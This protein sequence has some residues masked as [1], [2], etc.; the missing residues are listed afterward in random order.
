MNFTN[1][2]MLSGVIWVLSMFVVFWALFSTPIYI[3][4]AFRYFRRSYKFTL[5][6]KSNW[7]RFELTAPAFFVFFSGIGSALTL[8]ALLTGAPSLLSAL[9]GGLA[10]IALISLIVGACFGGSMHVLLTAWG[11]AYVDAFLDKNR[12]DKNELMLKYLAR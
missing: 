12:I 6:P 11:R 8:V 1:L 10:S 5:P 2:L 4:L 7:V 3:A 9:P